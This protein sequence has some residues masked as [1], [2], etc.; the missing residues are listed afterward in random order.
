[1][2]SGRDLKEEDTVV[3][4]TGHQL[5]VAADEVRVAEGK[6]VARR[7]VGS[8]ALVA[9][10]VLQVDGEHACLVLLLVVA[11]RVHGL[12]VVYGRD[13]QLRRQGLLG[14]VLL[15]AAVILDAWAVCLTDLVR[16]HVQGEDVVACHVHELGRARGKIVRLD[17]PA[18]FH[19]D[20]KLLSACLSKLHVGH[21]VV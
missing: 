20:E 2:I 10:Y 11:V 1:M 15:D 3:G 13:E 16:A 12:A 19:V 4:G 17:A 9:L 8:S 5:V 6:E 14:V 18:A 21:Y 7:Q